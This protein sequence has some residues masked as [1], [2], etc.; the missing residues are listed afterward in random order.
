MIEKMQIILTHP[1]PTNVFLFIYCSNYVPIFVHHFSPHSD[2]III[3]VDSLLSCFFQFSDM[4]HIHVLPDLIACCVLMMQT[5]IQISI[6]CYHPDRAVN[7][8]SVCRRRSS[9]PTKTHHKHTILVA[10]TLNL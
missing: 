6:E 7:I 3:F 10:I 5:S 9:L 8:L 1:L 2:P 4:M